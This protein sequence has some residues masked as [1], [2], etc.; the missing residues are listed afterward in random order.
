[1]RRLLWLVSLIIC[2]MTLG[3]EREERKFHEAPPSHQRAS[4]IPLTDLQPGNNIPF[5][6]VK[7]PYEENAYAVSEGQR[8]FDW[9]NCSGCH[10]HGGGGSGPAL[11]DDR[12]VYGSE[13]AQIFS[14][15]VE[16]RPNGMPSFRDKLPE[17]QIWQL[18]AY[19]RSMA[20]LLKKDVSPGRPD[21]MHM[22][23]EEQ[24]MEETKP[25]D[26]SPSK[27]AEM[28]K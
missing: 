12:W 19:I 10:A 9:Y 22:K 15:I 21:N 24:A 25:K 3:C 7:N 6:D 5:P 14:T 2:A 18:V 26:S 1:M 16:G 28:P 27:S 20:G 23:V 8:L 17:Y 13:P 4:G 11:M